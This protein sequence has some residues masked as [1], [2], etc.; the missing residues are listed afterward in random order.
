M[1]EFPHLFD[2][3][4]NDP[5]TGDE[6]RSK[7]KQLTRS[8]NASE[9]DTVVKLFLEHPCGSNDFFNCS[10]NYVQA[11][12]HFTTTCNCPFCLCLCCCLLGKL[13]WDLFLLSS[14]ILWGKVVFP[15]DIHLKCEM[16]PSQ[17]ESIALH[18]CGIAETSCAQMIVGRI[19]NTPISSN[20]VFPLLKWSKVHNG[21][22]N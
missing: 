12:N 7:L 16:M 3:L 8:D 19:H 9:Q 2:E 11:I 22:I 14:A 15:T 21:K 17:K 20:I 6:T 13:R 4:L 5:W 1:T 10:Q 18:K